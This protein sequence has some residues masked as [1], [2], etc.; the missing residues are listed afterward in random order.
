M[1]IKK[2]IQNYP[3]KH[4]DGFTDT[5]IKQ[6]L[7]EYPNINLNKFHNALNGITGIII[8]KDFL[9]YH[10]DVELALRCGIENRDS[11]VEEWD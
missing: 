8:D 4:K 11:N 3:T 9:T 2:K 6:L 1:E 7:K 5:E 10:C